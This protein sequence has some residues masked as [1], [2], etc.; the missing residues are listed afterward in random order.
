M[1]IESRAVEEEE[2]LE[3][4]VALSLLSPPSTDGWGFR[5]LD[6]AFTRRG[7]PETCVPVGRNTVRAVEGFDGDMSSC[8]VRSSSSGRYV[9]LSKLGGKGK[10]N[11]LPT[12]ID[13]MAWK[14]GGSNE[15]V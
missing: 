5:N 3:G 9:D 6:S 13:E 10:D 7:M 14:M 8:C 11:E 1:K 12:T 2:D 15:R 4:L